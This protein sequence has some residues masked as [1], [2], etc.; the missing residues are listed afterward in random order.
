[1]S[2]VREE[3]RVAALYVRCMACGR[4]AIADRPVTQ[5]Q[6]CGGLFDCDLPLERPIDAS[7]FGRGLPDNLAFS[8]VWRYRPLLPA[9]P[10]GAIVSRAEGRTPIYWDER[11]A[12]F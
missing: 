1:M 12:A 5:C 8:G 2:P 11:L 6:H 4:G 10:D 7:A 3:Q 9:I